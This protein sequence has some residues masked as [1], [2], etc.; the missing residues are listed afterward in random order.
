MD[1]EITLTGE[2]DEIVYYNEDNGYAVFDLRTEDENLITCT[3]CI[4]NIFLGEELK[5]TGSFEVHKTYGKQLKV[6]SY[7]RCEMQS[8]Y[9]IINYL[10]SGL[11]KGIGIKTAERIVKKYKKETFDVIENNFEDL[12]SIKGVT[13]EKAKSIHDEFILRNAMKSYIMDM[14][15]LGLSLNL[16]MK[17]YDTY[18][19]DSVT[20]LKNN[21]YMYI[22]KIDDYTFSIADM[23]A[24]KLQFAKDSRERVEQGI[25]CALRNACTFGNVYLPESELVETSKQVLGIYDDELIS[26]ILKGMLD[27]RKLYVVEHESRDNDIYLKKYYFAEKDISDKLRIMIG[28]DDSRNLLPKDTPAE[29]KKREKYKREVSKKQSE[30]NKILDELDLNL[31]D[32][33]YEAVLSSLLNDVSI[34]TGGPG[35]GKTTIINVICKYYGINHKKTIL[36]APTG[37]AAKRMAEATMQKAMTIHR[38]L[39]VQPATIENEYQEF[40]RNEDNPIEADVLIVDEMSMVDVLLFNSLLK[41][42]EIGTKLILV[43]DDKQL[44]SV[45]PGNVLRD[46][47]E[48]KTI[49]TSLLTEVYRQADKSLIIK[50]AHKIRN[51]EMPEIKS[52]NDFFFVQTKSEKETVEQILTLVEERLPKFLDCSSEEIQVLSP[53]KKGELGTVRLNEIL[54]GTLNPKQSKLKNSEV[55]LGP[56]TFRT[57]DKVMQ[58]KNDY[59]M[60]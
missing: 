41:A 40:G 16:A 32:K 23:V 3:G 60:E 36:V 15:N 48:S 52:D 56:K 14:Q 17:I 30:I 2:V 27:E 9:S 54:Q 25:A 5:L 18:R 34:I 42:V 51:N 49:K 47:I 43:G 1:K 50:N 59:E 19:G 58:I 7:E 26:N 46:L 21:P 31:S 39:E 6:S 33:Q 20:F 24:E 4:F 55:K 10:S 44:P 12:V 35:T 37:R 11:F 53:M 28:L 29:K 22:D 8:T 38:L 57:G 45:G 13:L